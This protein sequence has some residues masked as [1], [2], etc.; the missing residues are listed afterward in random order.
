VVKVDIDGISLEAQPDEP[1]TNLIKRLTVLGGRSPGLLPLTGCGFASAFGPPLIAY[2][3]QANGSFGEA[4][5][6]I[7]GDGGFD[8]GSLDRFPAP[9]N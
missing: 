6:V 1:L 9:P 3:R 7:A 2:M 5:P 4:L 8:R